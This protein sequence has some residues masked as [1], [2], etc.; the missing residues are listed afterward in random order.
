MNFWLFIS[1]MACG[2]I[3]GVAACI[4]VLAYYEKDAM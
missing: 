1:G 2:L 3:L 4:A